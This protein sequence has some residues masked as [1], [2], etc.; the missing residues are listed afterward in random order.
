[1]ASSRLAAVLGKRAAVASARLV[2]QRAGISSS[3]LCPAPVAL[4]VHLEIAQDRVD[5]FKDVMTYDAAE[6]R[7]EAG[8]L[9]FDLLQDQENAN[10]FVLYEA[11]EGEDAIAFHK[12]TPHYKMWTDFKDEGGVVSASVTKADGISFTD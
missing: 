8:C 1:M 2:A 3:A 12:N 11:Y 10:K 4:V 7:K 9:R 6:S 5:K